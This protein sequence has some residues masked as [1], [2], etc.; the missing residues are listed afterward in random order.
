MALQYVGGTSATGTAATYAVS[1]TSLS[2]GVDTQPRAGDMVLVWTGF[3]ATASAAPTVRTSNA[4]YGGLGAAAY[5]NATYDTNARGFVS[6]QGANPDTSITVSR[7]SSTAYGGGAAVQVWRGQDE[8]TPIPVVGTPATTINASRGNPPSVTPNGDGQIVV[9]MG[10]GTQGASGSAFTP[11]AELTDNRISINADGS[12]SDIG[13]WIGSVA[14]ANGVATDPSAW[15]GGATSTS[16]SAVGQTVVLAPGTAGVIPRAVYSTGATVTKVLSGVDVQAGDTV[17]VVFECSNSVDPTTSCS[18]GTAAYDSLGAGITGASCSFNAFSHKYDSAQ[19]GLTLTVTSGNTSNTGVIAL[20]VPG[21]DGPVSGGY[22]TAYD[23]T[24]ATSHATA[25]VTAPAGGAYVVT[26]A[27][28]NSASSTYLGDNGTWFAAEGSLTQFGATLPQTLFDKTVP[29]GSVS[30]SISSNTSIR[31]ASFIAAFNLAAAVTPANT[32]L[33]FTEDADTLALA[34]NVPAAATLAFTEDSD[35]F[36]LHSGQIASCTLT[37]TDDPDTV[38]LQ[39]TVAALVARDATL[40]VTEAA[41]TAALVSGVLAKTTLAITEAADA[42]ALAASAPA[43]AVLAVAEAADTLALA[44]N[45]AVGARAQVQ[46]DADV[47]AMAMGVQVAGVLQVVESP[48]FVYLLTDGGNPSDAKIS[49]AGMM[50]NTGFLLLR[51]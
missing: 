33:A 24:A 6:I 38:S 4:A 15:T 16:C 19:T 32:T 21:L 18:D 50:V 31:L 47:V 13:V 36:D 30:Q 12:T 8:T 5:A 28:Q 1:L 11:S 40:A 43:A 14:G 22:A 27:C 17:I 29:A 51:S 35:T 42:L 7:T 34:G 39:A 48:D 2:G 9:G 44:G 25:S 10:A 3:G 26:F 23:G 46:E 37:A 45:V 41:D 49:T 20:V